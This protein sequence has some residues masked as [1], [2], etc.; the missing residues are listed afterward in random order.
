[1]TPEPFDP[2]KPI[3]YVKHVSRYGEMIIGWDKEMVP[4]GNYT[5]IPIA[6]VAVRSWEQ[7][8]ADLHSKRRMLEGMS[9]LG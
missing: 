4:P 3:P 5:E 6:Q 7:V 2:L 1:M 8:L 9:T